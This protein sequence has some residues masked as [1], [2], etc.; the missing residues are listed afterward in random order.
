MDLLKIKN[1]EG[2]FCLPNKEE[3]LVSQI[4]T[5]D[6]DAALEL[7]LQ[8]E[9]I[10]LGLDD[11]PEAIKNPAQKIIFVQL[12]NSFQEVLDSRQAILSEINEAFADVENKY[13]NSTDM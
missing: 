8:R 12:R 1:S 4:T 11:D 2:Y 5:K 9:D 6:I 3:K 13:L 10:D 7:I